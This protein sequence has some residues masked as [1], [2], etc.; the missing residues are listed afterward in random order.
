MISPSHAVA[1][2]I[3]QRRCAAF[4]LTLLLLAAVPLSAQQKYYPDQPLPDNLFLPL[5]HIHGLSD[6]V[7]YIGGEMATNTTTG[8][9]R[10]M[11]KW[12]CPDKVDIDQRE[13]LSRG[14]MSWQPKKSTRKSFAM[15]PFARA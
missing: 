2:A 3:A 12:T 1:W 6:T 5:L 14:G 7:F 11:W 4:I 15:R 9:V 13:Y 10:D 8:D